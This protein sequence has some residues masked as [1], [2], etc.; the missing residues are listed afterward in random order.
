MGRSCTAR[1]GGA[2]TEPIGDKKLPAWEVAARWYRARAWRQMIGDLLLVHLSVLLA[3]ALRYNAFPLPAGALAGLWPFFLPMAVFR[4]LSLRAFRIY[5]I[6]WRFVGLHELRALLSATTVSSLGFYL[7]LIV[8]RRWEYPRGVLVIDWLL[9]VF[10]IGGLRISY[11]LVLASGWRVRS[12]AGRRVL[13]V[14]AGVHGEALARELRH[15][16]QANYHLIGFLDDAPS[17]QGLVIQGL[18]VLGTVDD[19]A[20]ITMARRIDEV[21]I[22]IPT[23]TGAQIR[24]IVGLCEAL[25]VRLKIAPGF[26]PDADRVPAL[27][28]ISVEDLLR[29]PPVRINVDEVAGYLAGERVLV[30]GAGGSIGSE[31][32]RQA[33]ALDPECLLL[34]GHGENSIFQIHQEL[35]ERGVDAVP[36]VADVKDANRLNQI[37]RV[38]QP[39]VVFHAAAHKHV[40]LMEAHP[41]EAVTNNILG[42]RNLV[43]LAAQYRVKRFVMISSD[44]AVNPTSVMGA[45]KRVAELIV[46]AAALRV[47]GVQVSGTRAAGGCSGV[48]ENESQHLNTRT[49]RAPAEHPNT[50]FM[51]VRFGNVLGSRGSVVPTMLRCIQQGRPVPVTHPA[52]VRYFMTIPEAVLLLLQAGALGSHGELFMLDMGEPVRIVDLARDLI[53]LSGLVPEKDVPIQFTGLR[54]GEKLYEELLTSAEGATVTRHEKIFVA[55]SAPIDADAL[56]TDVDRLAALAAAGDADG[57]RAL[58]R[59]L[60]PTYHSPAPAPLPEHAPASAPAPANHPAVVTEPTREPRDRALPG[61]ATAGLTR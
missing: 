32:C 42:T 55:A 17:K 6:H 57:I 38:H 40:P 28:D 34:L 21:V 14:G 4:V 18:P 16:G 24:R 53:R 52:M 36:L 44:K 49:Q 31:L 59:D 27:R 45:S 3:F 13:I 48:Q 33:A 61:G 5:R 56:D 20:A 11:R 2:M 15:H 46:Q 25:P 9:N 10:L 1:D 50:R 39:T 29:R 37:F 47:S 60:V 19:V 26:R 43:R 7:L 8:C 12:G 54:P 22:A 41:G 30:T 23:A 58:L 51:A 35:Q